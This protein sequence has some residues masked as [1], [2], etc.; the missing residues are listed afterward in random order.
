MAMNSYQ[1]DDSDKD[2]TENQNT[3]VC[4]KTLPKN[5]AVYDI[6]WKIMIQTNRPQMIIITRRRKDI[7]GMPDA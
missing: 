7:N 4:S 3:Y 2:C 6:M 1:N 5:R